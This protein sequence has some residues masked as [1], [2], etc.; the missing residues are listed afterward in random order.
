MAQKAIQTDLLG[1]QVKVLKDLK[2][3]GSGKLHEA[4]GK[5]G[6]I[7]N[8]YYDQEGELKYTIQIF[9]TG[10]LVELYPHTFLI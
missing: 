6:A 7:R 9:D 1:Q 4:A 10:R 3:L 8:V 2:I 5:T